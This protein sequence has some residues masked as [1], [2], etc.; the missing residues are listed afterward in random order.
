MT[1]HIIPT[2]QDNYTYAIENDRGEVILID[3]GEAPPVIAFLKEKNLKP[4]ALLC[5]HHHWDH[6][7]GLPRLIEEFPDLP[8]YAAEQ[9]QSRIHLATHLLNDGDEII[10]GGI[11]FSCIETSGHTKN[12]LCFYAAALKALFS[13]DTLFS[14][15]CGRLLE[16]T[17]EEMFHSLQILKA[18]PDDT[19]IYCGHEYT[20][21]NAEF[22]SAHDK[23]SND[24]SERM[25]QITDLR[26]NDKPTLPVTLGIEKKTNLFLK[27]ESI[28]KFAQLRQL[29]D[30]F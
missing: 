5:T 16:G 1:I 4:V 14:L 8:I 11:S 12:H 29:R 17:A 25:K 23:G 19:L 13:G 9:D 18:L 6:I 24:L 15:G 30:H 22:T 21:K 10:L 26:N 3:C 7:D 2:L 27:A 20:L 28:E